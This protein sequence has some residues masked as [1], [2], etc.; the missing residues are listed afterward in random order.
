M[1][2][3]SKSGVFWL[4]SAPD[5]RVPGELV[6]DAEGLRPAAF[7]P[8]SEPLGAGQIARGGPHGVHCDRVYAEFFDGQAA[9]LL[10]SPVS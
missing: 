2:P 10:A 8:L 1:Q 3:F 7:Q 5:R 6:L 9:T 4:A